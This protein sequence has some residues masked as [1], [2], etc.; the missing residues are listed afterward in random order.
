MLSSSSKINKVALGEAKNSKYEV[1]LNKSA[2]P[3]DRVVENL[4]YVKLISLVNNYFLLLLKAS[5]ELLLPTQIH[6]T[7]FISLCLWS[8]ASD[9][10][11]HVLSASLHCYSWVPVP[12]TLPS[13]F[14]L[15]YLIHSLSQHSQHL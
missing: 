1:L 7:S 9:Q 11:C 5:K 3:K 14:Q 15:S 6:F 12:G 8:S 2:K 4:C 13:S 10:A